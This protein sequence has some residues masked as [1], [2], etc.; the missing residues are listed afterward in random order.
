MLDEAGVDVEPGEPVILRR[1]LSA[2]GRS[3]AHVNDQPASVDCWRVWASAG[4][5][6]RPA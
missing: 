1:T 5:D 6:S 2:D 4:G 3:R